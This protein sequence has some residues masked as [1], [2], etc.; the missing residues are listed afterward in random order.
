MMSEQHFPDTQGIHPMMAWRIRQIAKISLGKIE[1]TQEDID[2]LH[3][4]IFLL[5][6]TIG[7]HA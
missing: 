7:Q 6:R 3:R 4:E 5:D 1:G 2:R